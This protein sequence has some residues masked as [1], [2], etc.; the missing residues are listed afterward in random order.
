[1]SL[2]Y[3][4]TCGQ[5][6]GGKA[7]E[8]EA[9]RV[10]RRLV[11]NDSYL[12]RVGGYLTSGDEYGVYVSRNQHKKPIMKLKAGMLSGFAAN[13]WIV[14]KEKERWCITAQGEAWLRRKM[15]ANDPYRA[16]HQLIGTKTIKTEQNALR[17]LKVNFAES[18]L[19]WLLHRKGIDGKPLISQEQYEA[20]E[21]LRS[22]FEKA[23]MSPRITSDI[24]IPMTS[25]SGRRAG[26]AGK[27]VAI[28]DAA[29][30][31]KERFFKAL[32]VVGPD[33]ADVLIEV[34]CHLKG[35]DE[36]EKQL[37]LPQR[38]GKIVLQIALRRLGQHYGLIAQLRTH[39]YKA[40][41][42]RHWGDKT[43]RPE[44]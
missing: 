27:G 42:M 3:T 31:A 37:R 21:R 29:I 23:Q 41:A 32:D 6:V 44:I 30:A 1:M 26:D 2:Q 11:E 40:S 36:A 22:D 4:G 15:S 35:M 14:K 7:L 24:T 33:L 13:D 10:F 39:Q 19:G 16:Q 20:G 34:C 17:T 18:P 12:A 28:R 38:S 8:Q 9:T 25:S 43:Y 5:Q